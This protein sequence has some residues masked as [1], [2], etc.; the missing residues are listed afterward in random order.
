[1]N[2][3]DEPRADDKVTQTW[4][5]WCEGEVVG[6]LVESRREMWN[7]SCAFSPAVAFARH[8]QLFAEKARVADLIAAS[9]D[10]TLIDQWEALEKET[11]PPRFQLT[12]A[13]GR[14]QPFSML[15]IEGDEAGLRLV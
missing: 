9:H 10:A 7:S 13:D 2:G 1:M 6:G 4:I 12:G 3:G 11:S 14:A 8:R 15:Y 5:L